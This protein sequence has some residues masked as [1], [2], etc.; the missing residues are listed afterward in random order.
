MTEVAPKEKLTGVSP[1][2][3]KFI[4]PNSFLVFG[5]FVQLRELSKFF[6][7]IRPQPPHHFRHLRRR[8]SCSLTRGGRF[9]RLVN[10]MISK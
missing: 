5:L 2:R 8:P 7:L 1:R 4:R 9:F 10:G 6:D 3:V